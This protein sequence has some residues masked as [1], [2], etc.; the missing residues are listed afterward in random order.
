MRL[1]TRGF[2]D[3]SRGQIMQGLTGHGKDFGFY[4][5][6]SGNPLAVSCRVYGMN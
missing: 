1:V 2:G 3:I 6:C 4:S 5:K